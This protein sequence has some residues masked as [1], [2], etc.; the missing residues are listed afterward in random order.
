[1]SPASF[2]PSWI[3]YSAAS[4]R[5]CASEN[6]GPPGSREVAEGD[7]AQAVAGGADLPVDLEAALELRPVEVAERPLEA[8][9]ELRRDR[10][11]AGSEGRSRQAEDGGGDEKSTLR[12]LFCFL[13]ARISPWIAAR[14]W[15]RPACRPHP[16]ARPSRI[17][18][19]NSAAAAAARRSR[20]AAGRSGSGRSSRPSQICE[21]ITYQPS[22]GLRAEPA[23]HDAD[24]HE[25]PEEL[26][27][28]R[29][30]GRGA[31]PRGV[32]PGHE[33]PDQRSPRTSR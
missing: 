17:R 16:S 11:L 26:L 13:D 31:H 7:V 6:S 8:P 24:G 32:E 2:G 12:S 3:L 1:M 18:G 29:P 15:R 20:A 4:A 19:S 9:L 5:T 28:E 22:A 30:V 21:A 27:V 23:E 14:H 10:G 25:D 33:A